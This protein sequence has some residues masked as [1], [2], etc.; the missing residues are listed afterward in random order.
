ME[1]SKGHYKHVCKQWMDDIHGWMFNSFDLSLGGEKRQYLGCSLSR[2]L[3][4][5]RYERHP[6]YFLPHALLDAG[7]FE[8]HRRKELGDD[9]LQLLIGLCMAQPKEHT[10][11]L[12][13][14]T[15]QTTN[16]HTEHTE[17]RLRLISSPVFVIN[18]TCDPLTNLTAISDSNMKVEL[19]GGS[20]ETR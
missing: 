8:E 3:C 12:I 14:Q 19:T 4:R 7:E 6:A 20:M 15:T 18:L 11:Q 2:I 16:E 13:C 17:H 9:V 10:L 1:G 5:H